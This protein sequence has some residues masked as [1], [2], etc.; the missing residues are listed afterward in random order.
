MAIRAE[1]TFSPQDY[2]V[3][4]REASRRGG[5]HGAV[6]VAKF[7]AMMAVPLGCVEAL[8]CAISPR[9]ALVCSA[10]SWTEVALSL[11]MLAAFCIAVGLLAILVSP[12]V[13]RRW[14]YRRIALADKRVQYELSDSGIGYDTPVATGVIRW[15]AVEAS[16]VFPDHLVLFISRLEGIPLPRRAYADPAR[17]QAAAELIARRTQRPA[18]PAAWTGALPCR[19][20]T[21][22]APSST[23]PCP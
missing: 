17:F 6:G 5:W 22:G 11:G 3:L 10:T 7:A 14:M 23:P 12:I 16:F 4:C 20:L 13:T 19:R 15:E 21:P 2:A 8:A 9:D 18:A 1:F